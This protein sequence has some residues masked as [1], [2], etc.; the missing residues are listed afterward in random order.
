MGTTH[1]GDKLE[2]IWITSKA[3]SEL[4]AKKIIPREAYYNV[5]NRV[6]FGETTSEETE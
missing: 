3:K 4:D 2:A 1:E 5:M 6:L